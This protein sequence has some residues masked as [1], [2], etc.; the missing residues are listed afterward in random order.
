MN[1]RFID[2]VETVN[3]WDNVTYDIH[4]KT[5]P[6]ALKAIKKEDEKMGDCITVIN[7]HTN[8]KIGLMVVKALQ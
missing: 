5:A 1:K 8:T 4:Y 7:W 6:N 2:I 3:G